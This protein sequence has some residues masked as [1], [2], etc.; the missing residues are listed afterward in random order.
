M[1]SADTLASKKPTWGLLCLF[2]SASVCKSLAASSVLKT[3][4]C[5]NHE[6]DFAAVLA[7]PQDGEL[8]GAVTVPIVA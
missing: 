2:G 6:M 4:S 3:M 1:S 5:V 7:D 8:M